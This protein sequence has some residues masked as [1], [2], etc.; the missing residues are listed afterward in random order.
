LK[1]IRFLILFAFGMQLTAGVALADGDAIMPLS[2]VRAGMACTGDTVVQGTAISSFNVRVIQ[3]VEVPSEGPRILVSV[4]GPAVDVT[5]LAEGF[6]GSPVYCPTPT[7]PANA[8][9][10]SAGVGQFGNSLGLVT[11]IEQMLGQP[12]EPPSGAARLALGTRQLLGPLAVSGVSPAMLRVLQQ[13]GLRAGRSVVSAPSGLFT[14]FPVQPLIP[15]A[16]VAISY[17]TGAIAVGAVGTVTY[18]K[19][20]TLYAFGHPLDD[21]GRRSLFL[22]DAYVY[23]VINDPIPSVSSSYKLAAVGHAEGTFTSDAPAA[24]IGAVGALPSMIP[25][26]V[27]VRDLDTG[28]ELNEL[29]QVADETDVGLP[30]GT[31]LLDL[32]APVAVG[33]AS[34]DVYDGPPA[35]ESGRMC[36][37]LDLRESRIPLQFCNR[38]VGTGSAGD[39]VQL[40][41][42]ASAT[43]SDVTTALGLL[44]AEQF[45]RLH[46]TRVTATISAQRGLAEAT[47][48]SAHAPARVQAGRPVR[49]H[50]RV[51]RFRG[52]L[53]TISFMLRIPRRV[54]GPLAVTLRGAPQPPSMGSADSLAAAL[55]ASLVGGGGASPLTGSAPTSLAS[56]RKQF[57]GIGIYDGLQARLGGHTSAHVYR[58]P[59]LLITGHARVAF[60]VGR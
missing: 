19:G 30:L 52:P 18:R 10:I 32:V 27:T 23:D 53:Q 46:V 6:S 45:A 33:Q 48:I 12:V 28:R 5:G 15:G 39:S 21:A 13:A 31:S 1:R 57:A 34:T 37:R 51:R 60:V 25:V 3:V 47:I 20:Q 16:S 8:G 7:G 2:Q 35:N 4:S 43:S 50:V 22:Q 36:L 14:S 55:G 38:Y 41:E 9:A 59:A 11:P 29:S 40:P 49:V 24:V 17:S 56:L 44:D 58:D 26:G 54:H 42:L